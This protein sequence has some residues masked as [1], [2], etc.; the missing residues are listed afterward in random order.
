MLNSHR[1]RLSVLLNIKRVKQHKVPTVDYWMVVRPSLNIQ[2]Y[3]MFMYDK[4]GNLT[5]LFL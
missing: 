1:Y 5:I 3:I 4:E 2:L